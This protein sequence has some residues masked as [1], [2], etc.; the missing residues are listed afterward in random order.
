MHNDRRETDCGDRPLKLAATPPAMHIHSMLQMKTYID[1]QAE[2]VLFS[3][4]K[5]IEVRDPFDEAHCVRVAN[6]AVRSERAWF[7]QT[8]LTR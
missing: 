1:E 8:I 7:D 4:A 3:L 6:N 5:S 2:S